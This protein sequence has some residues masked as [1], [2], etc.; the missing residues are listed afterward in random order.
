[1]TGTKGQGLRISS[2]VS[3]PSITNVWQLSRQRALPGTL[4]S[5]VLQMYTDQNLKSI[6]PN[7][8][9]RSAMP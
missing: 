4:R 2:W 1:M 6:Y 9:A 3:I 8:G 5:V 7:S